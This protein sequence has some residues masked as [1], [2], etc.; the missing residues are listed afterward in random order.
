MFFLSILGNK[1][2][3]AVA[4]P[5]QAARYLKT[6]KLQHGCYHCNWIRHS[7]LV[8][9]RFNSTWRQQLRGHS[10]RITAHLNRWR[11]DVLS[12]SGHKSCCCFKGK[13][14]T[15][16][17]FSRL[18]PRRMLQCYSPSMLTDTCFLQTIVRPI[19][20]YLKTYWWAL[21]PNGVSK[22]QTE[23]GWIVNSF[24]AYI[25][26]IWYPS[27]LHRNIP[28]AVVY[29]VDGHFSNIWCNKALCRPWYYTRCSDCFLNRWK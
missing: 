7:L 3:A 23:N 29:F 22:N 28:M 14:G 24:V 16:I 13:T 9:F 20:D 19:N 26:K 2:S 1:M 10:Y 21:I 4:W 11:N 15:Y 5:S 12:R 27:L 17:W 25:R 6:R 18:I 8:R